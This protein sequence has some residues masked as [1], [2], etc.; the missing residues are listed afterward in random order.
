[1]YS[2]ISTRLDL[3]QAVN[4]VYKFM[5]KLGKQHW[6]EV[7]WILRYLKGITIHRIMLN[8]EQSVS[9]V[10]GYVDSD[11]AVDLDDRKSTTKYVFTLA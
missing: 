7:K 4:Q 11:Y 2:I 5:S 9:S 8:M 6:E 3:A 1:M 10:V